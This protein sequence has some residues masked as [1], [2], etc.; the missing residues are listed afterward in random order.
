[1]QISGDKRQRVSPPSQP[2]SPRGGNHPTAGYSAADYYGNPYTGVP[3]SA[4]ASPH[5]MTAA[6]HAASV[7]VATAAAAA[8]AI[9]PPARSVGLG[10]DPS[11]L[12]DC[13]RCR[14]CLDK[15][16]NGGTG[17][18][19]RRCGPGLRRGGATRRTTRRATTTAPRTR[20]S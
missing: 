2:E 14:F 1:M 18:L 10:V 17:T 4:A 20:A 9:S 15:K 8:A 7:V 6:A 13:N 5:G 3:A 16:R 12:P 19:R 11:T